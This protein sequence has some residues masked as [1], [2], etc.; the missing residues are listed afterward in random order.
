MSR[1]SFELVFLYE[2]GS[3]E[4]AYAFDYTSKHPSCIAILCRSEEGKAYRALRTRAFITE[5]YYD[6]HLTSGPLE[7]PA[8]PRLSSKLPAAFFARTARRIRPRSVAT[9]P[10]V[11]RPSAGTMVSPEDCN[12]GSVVRYLRKHDPWFNIAWAKA[13]TNVGRG[14]TMLEQRLRSHVAEA[15][16]H[17]ESYR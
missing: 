5:W 6:P 16:R 13:G 3:Q 17:C 2:A 1:V 8:D 14:A 15:M 7:I 12:F 4:Y 11:G 9:A 10:T